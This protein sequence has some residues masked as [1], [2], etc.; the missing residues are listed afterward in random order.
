M[1]AVRL[2]EA[3]YQWNFGEGSK[4]YDKFSPGRYIE[5]QLKKTVVI[6]DIVYQKE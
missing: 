1:Q 5:R 6:I 2:H 4:G 3:S